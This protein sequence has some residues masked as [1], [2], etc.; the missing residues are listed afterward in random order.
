MP[1]LGNF[2]PSKFN[3]AHYTHAPNLNV[4][5]RAFAPPPPLTIFLNESLAMMYIVLDSSALE[6]SQGTHA[7]DGVSDSPE[8]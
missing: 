1:P 7:N 4:F 5:R 6:S 2:N 8:L 3:T